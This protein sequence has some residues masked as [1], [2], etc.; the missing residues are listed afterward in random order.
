[1]YGMQGG[2]Q[3]GANCSANYQGYGSSVLGY[4]TP[5]QSQMGGHG[6]HDGGRE[7][8][9]DTATATAPTKG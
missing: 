3:D 7:G 8:G 1:M 4:Y 2:T 6:G 5:G 9:A